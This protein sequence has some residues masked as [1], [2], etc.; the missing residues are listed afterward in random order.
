MNEPERTYDLVPA[1]GLEVAE[2]DTHERH[3]GGRERLWSV[4]DHT[5]VLLVHSEQ[6]PRHFLSWK[7]T[8]EPT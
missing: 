2:L 3:V 5:R 6:H 1:V 8:K 4:A 7:D